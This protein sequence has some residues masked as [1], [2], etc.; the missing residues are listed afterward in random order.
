MAANLKKYNIQY[1]NTL[2]GASG[3]RVRGFKGIGIAERF[4]VI[5]SGKWQE[6]SPEEDPQTK[7][8][9]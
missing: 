7:M 6:V 5:R 1:S 8:W 9:E 4:P 3:R 2:L